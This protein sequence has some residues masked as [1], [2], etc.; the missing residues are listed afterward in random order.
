MRHEPAASPRGVIAWF[1]MREGFIDDLVPLRRRSATSASCPCP[2]WLPTPENEVRNATRTR[3]GLGMEAVEEVLGGGP[4]SLPAAEL[5][6]RNGDMHGV[7]EVGLQELP[8]DRNAATEAYV[9]RISCVLG[10]L[11][12]LRGRGIEEV[13]R[14]VGQREARSVVVGKNKHGRME[15]RGASP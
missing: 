2:R 6:R 7:D 12:R 8:D 1:D 14:G 13:E 15:G 9:L 11:H 5:D 10:P 3:H 4:E